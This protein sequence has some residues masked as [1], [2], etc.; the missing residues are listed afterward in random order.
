MVFP[1][2]Y[3]LHHQSLEIQLLPKLE[4]TTRLLLILCVYQFHALVQF[5][6]KQY[7]LLV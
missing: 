2:E 7:K 3:F 6:L 5:P 1:P 4:V